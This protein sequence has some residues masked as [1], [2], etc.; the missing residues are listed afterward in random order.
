MLNSKTTLILI[1]LSVIAIASCAI[2]VK[3]PDSGGLLLP[4]KTD[5]S[6][7][8]A[9]MFFSVRPYKVGSQSES[10][11]DFSVNIKLDTM[12]E[13]GIRQIDFSQSN[14]R[15]PDPAFN[16][17]LNFMDSMYFRDFT[18]GLYLDT[19]KNNYSSFYVMSNN[20]GIGF[21]FGGEKGGDAV[22]GG[23]DFAENEPE[24]L[25]LLFRYE[26]DLTDDYKFGLEFNGDSLS[27][28]F[29]VN[30]IQNYNFMI[31]YIATNDYDDKYPL[32]D[33]DRFVIGVKG[34]F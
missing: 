24:A 34:E 21:N 29:D 3:F 5:Y 14:L 28:Y 15:T 10:I 17:K 7:S 12:F 32:L 31:G 30:T 2:G 23:Y 27:S 13:L 25:F 18:V 9:E 4:G 6:Y 26:F 20:F 19:E 11:Y 8:D 33:N 16:L 1:F 22:L